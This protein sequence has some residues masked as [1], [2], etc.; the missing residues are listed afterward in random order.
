MLREEDGC[1]EGFPIHRSGY[2]VR[3]KVRLNLNEWELALKPEDPVLNMHIAEGSPLNPEA[4]AS[5]L[6]A[7]PGFFKKYLG[8][9]GIKALTCFSWLM[10]DNIGQL[11]PNGNIASFQRNFYLIPHE[12]SSD[13][14]TRQR[15]FGDPD[16]DI[17]QAECCTS[18]QKAI[19]AWYAAGRY[20]RHAAGFILL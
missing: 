17:L 16:I 15:V 11:Q 10:D 13:W 7:A 19:A 9:S 8:I 18:L 20:C 6:A 14:Q 12:R 2:A 1:A 5:S 3:A 4:V